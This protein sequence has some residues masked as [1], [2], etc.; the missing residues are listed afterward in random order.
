MKIGFF[1]TARL[2]S[3]RLKQK[4]LLDLNG[5][6]VLDR[7]IERAKSVEGV[8]DVVLCTSTNPQDAV[9]EENAL[10]NKIRFFTGSEDDVLRRLSDAAEYFQYDAF[11]SITADNPL[12]C[13]ETSKM[14][15]EWNRKDR[16]DFMFTKGL[17]IGCA[18]YL[19][20]VEALKLAIQ[21]KKESD[22]EIWGPFVNREDFFKIGDLIVD[23]S[24]FKEEKRLTIDYPEDYS[25]M[26]KIYN[27]FSQ[28]SVLSLRYVLKHLDDDYW[29]ININRKQH[30]TSND[31][32]EKIN[33]AFEVFKNNNYQRD[34]G[35]FTKVVSI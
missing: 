31:D 14:L 4:I 15:V 13:I 1:I 25:L 35:R 26:Q 20:N 19:L 34:K 9:L 30:F 10:K 3:T 8:D 12:F 5:K 22:T 27:D 32:L 28:D 33:A 6:S 17:P 23:N 21:I 29:N 16:F 24:P 7:I 18:T 2:K 11:L